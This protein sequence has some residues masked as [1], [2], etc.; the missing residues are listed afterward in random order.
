MAVCFAYVR[1]LVVG[2]VGCVV[3]IGCGEEGE[4]TS[5]S[6][7]GGGDAGASAVGGAG[8]SGGGT[9][10]TGATGGAGGSGGG[11]TG[12]ECVIHVDG[13]NGADASSGSSWGAAKATV[14]AGIQA[15]TRLTCIDPEVW[16]RSGTYFATS[17]DDRNASFAL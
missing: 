16:V 15:A 7:A 3:I 5:G 11:G 8:G 1:A 6:G 17:G 14:N 13:T 4:T 12:S 10:A 9:G 2:L